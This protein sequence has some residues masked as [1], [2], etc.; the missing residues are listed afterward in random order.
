MKL[1]GKLLMK[2]Y[3]DERENICERLIEILKLDDKNSFL[4]YNLDC[5]VEKQENIL[6]MKVELQMYFDCITMSAFNPKLQVSRPYLNIV[7]NI[8]RQQNYKIEIK[9]SYICHGNGLQ[10]KTAKYTIS[11]DIN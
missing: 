4:L 11:R 2:T 10:R 3:F 9:P 8:L 1:F 7:R 5:D 6:K